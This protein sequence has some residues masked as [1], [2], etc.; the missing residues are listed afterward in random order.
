MSLLGSQSLDLSS[1]D[2]IPASTA[3]VGIQED[4]VLE[5]PAKRWAPGV[6]TGG[7]Q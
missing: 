7:T 2:G 6:Q 3:L 4:L 5:V 1:G